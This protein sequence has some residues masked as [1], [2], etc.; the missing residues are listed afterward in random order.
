MKFKSNHTLSKRIKKSFVLQLGQSDCGVACLSSIIRFYSE[1]ESLQNL[2]DLS[3]TTITGTTLLGLLH[4]LESL[5]Y[6]V[7]A[8][9]ADIE[10]LTKLKNPIIL[11]VVMNTNR[12]HY[13]VN[14]G[15]NGDHFIIGDPAYGIVKY[16]KEELDNIWVSK[17]LLLIEP[18]KTETIKKK[19]LKR[20]WFLSLI[21]DDS[22]LIVFSFFLGI[23]V[24]L[25]GLIMAVFSQK[26]IDEIL[27]SR[28]INKLVIAIILVTLLLTARALLIFMR[29]YFII[30]QF[31]NFNVRI[32]DRFY[33]ELLYLPK[34][35]FDN[36][37]VGELVARLNDT[38]RIQKVISKLIGST[39]INVLVTITSL[40][41]V[42]YYSWQTGLIITFSLPVYYLIINRFNDKIIFAQK[43]TMQGYAMSESN[44]IN[45]IHGIATIK[46]NNKEEFFQA[47]NRDIYS[48]YQDKVFDL[49]KINIKLNLLSGLLGT[50]FMIVVISYCANLVLSSSMAIGELVAILGIAG[51]LLTTVSDL[52]LV[53]IPINEAQ[54]AFNRMFELASL[55]NEKDGNDNFDGNHISLKIK[56]LRFN[57]PGRTPLLQNINFSIDKGECLAIIGESGCGKSTL[58]QIFQKLYYYDN[59]MISVNG[60]FELSNI[61][62]RSWRKR[63]G[64]ISQDITLFNGNVLD[65]ILLGETDNKEKVESFCQEFGF[66]TF[67]EGLPNGYLTIVGEEGIN[68]SSGQKQ[69]LALIR[70]IYKKPKFL[71]LDEFTSAMDVKTESF[72]FN[73]LSI[74]KPNITILFITHRLNSIWT[75]ADK[76][77]VIENKKSVVSHSHQE[78]LK[79][80]SFYKDCWMASS[81]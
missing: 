56:E 76:V 63:V 23:I 69:I 28:N 68:L 13:I 48:T 64:V 31:K 38:Q 43:A 17:A 70:A 29:D 59:G 35:F 37:K 20:K 73:I 8:G 4:A 53:F 58:S 14:Y 36:R 42:Y 44:Y 12:Q 77:C 51:S 67:I 50:L 30:S 60:S 19:Y 26:L 10:F 81:I 57:Y 9:T 25:L 11:H 24:S 34:S 41:V 80:S 71:I 1:E 74:L 45:S 22:K 7:E 33:K 46:N 55:N 21:K 72:V 54:I 27:P 40:S 62:N 3:G 49:S 18:K 78:L 39:I 32:I 66:N 61:S 47:I 2:R 16:S 15:F 65:N 6:N 5:E 79:L 75:I 52:A